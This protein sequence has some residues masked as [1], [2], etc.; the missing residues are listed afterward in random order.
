MKFQEVTKQE[1]K[2]IKPVIVNNDMIEK[3]PE[4]DLGVSR[5]VEEVRTQE[6]HRKE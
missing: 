1:I 4:D 6:S 3:A 2:Q 5:I